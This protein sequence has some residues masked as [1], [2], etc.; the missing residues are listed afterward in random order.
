VL[1]LGNLLKSSAEQRAALTEAGR[2]IVRLS[3]WPARH[4]A[5]QQ[6]AG[7]GAAGGATAKRY[8]PK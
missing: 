4:G 2:E 6:A 5:A 1:D 8:E 3:F 7:H